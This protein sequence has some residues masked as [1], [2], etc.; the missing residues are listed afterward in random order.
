MPLWMATPTLKKVFLKP[1]GGGGWCSCRCSFQIPIGASLIRLFLIVLPVPSMK[2]P[3]RSLLVK[4]LPRTRL[5]SPTTAIP[6]KTVWVMSLPLLA[7]PPI[8]M[9]LAW[10]KIPTWPWA[11]LLLL[12]ITPS[13]ASVLSS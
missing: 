1:G 9:G 11:T 5:L 4:L 6:S 13:A 7:L 2:M 8:V 12:T 10:A 3:D